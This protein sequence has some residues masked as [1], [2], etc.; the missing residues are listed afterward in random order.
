MFW[1]VWFVV[2]FA[3]EMVALFRPA[4]G[5][6]LSE[7]LWALRDNPRMVGSFSFVMA[8]LIW[9]VYHFIKEGRP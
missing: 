5:D 3:V 2:G 9:S 6:T 7:Q 4:R 1:K 8:I